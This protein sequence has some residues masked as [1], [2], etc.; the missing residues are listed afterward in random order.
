MSSD[1]DSQ[2]THSQDT[3]SNV[4]ISEIYSVSEL[5]TEVRDLIEEH[6]PSV[7]VEG[8]ISNLARP[9][10]GHIYF[11]LKDESAQVRC[12]MFR[13]SNRLLKFKPENGTQVLLRARVSLY[14]ARGDFQLI[15]DYMEESGDGLLRR[16]FE[17]LKADLAQEG[18]FDAQHKQEIPLLPTRIG[19]ITSPSGAAIRDV[20]SVLQRRFPAIP[21]LIYPIPVQ[22]DDAP[23]RIVRMIKKACQ[24][25]ECDV[26]ILT[27]GGG[28]LEDLWAFNDEKVARAIFDCAIPIVC[29]VGHEIDSTIADFV[30]DVRSPTPS[31]AAEL[32]SPDRMEWLAGFMRSENR[33]LGL[34]KQKLSNT[35]QQLTWLRKRIQ[36]PRQRIQR[37]AQRLD[38]MEQ[39]LVH[40]QQI[41]QHTTRA[42]L[43]TL[44]TRLQQTN[45]V[46]RL[47]KLTM[48]QQ[49]LGQ[50]LQ[51]AMTK[52]LQNTQ[53]QFNTLSRALEAV[54]PLATL[55]RGYAIVRKHPEGDIIRDAKQLKSGEQLLTQLQHGS[56]ISTV[57]ETKDK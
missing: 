32:V 25:N 40:V 3:L 24:R 55:G 10:S 2:D 15:V 6:F 26:L 49:T 44:A 43:T 14:E 22:G 57:N 42:R 7:W 28:S 11:S 17:Q 39:R 37:I 19:V 30:A 50:R 38:E 33:L 27:R 45:P 8:E 51:H 46:H 54:S 1:H 34:I 48:V 18:L 13:M 12:A 20:L 36:H 29:G 56:V 23:P 47:E 41:Y 21:V 5:N 31:A 9:A 4:N 35:K 53:Y 16:K 52:K